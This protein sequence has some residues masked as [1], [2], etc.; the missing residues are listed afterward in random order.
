MKKTFSIKPAQV[1]QQWYLIDAADAPLGRLASEAAKLLIGKHKPTYT[2]H[3]DGGDHV[4]IIN[5]ALV[6]VTGNKQKSKVYSRHSGYPGGITQITLEKQLEKDPTKV[7]QMAIKGMLPKNKL[8]AGR[9]ARLRVFAD[10]NHTHG[11]QQPTVY[12]IKGDR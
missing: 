10:S 6:P 12:N 11:P 8:V 2:A 5:A 4:V 7:I 3:I 1:S 9:M